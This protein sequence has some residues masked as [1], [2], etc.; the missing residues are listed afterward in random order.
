MRVLITGGA[1]FVAPYVVA[2]LRA[3]VHTGLQLH[4]TGQSAAGTIGADPIHAL[5]VTDAA[6]VDKAVAAVLPTHVVHL[7]GIS[8]LPAAAADPN[9]AW[10]VNVLGTLNLA[11]SVLRHT[12]EAVF[13]FAG[14]SQAY[15]GAPSHGGPLREQDPLLP[16]SEYGATKAAADLGLGVLALEGLRAIRFRLFNHTGP[17]QPENFAVP[18]F[19]GQ[20]VRIERGLQ[21]PVIHVG[22]LEAERDILDVRDVADAYAAAILRARTIPAGTILNIASGR[23]TRI[24]NL[25][26]EL[27]AMAHLPV[28]VVVD[29]A[30]WRQNDIPVLVGDPSAARALLAWEPKISL[31]QTISDLLDARRSDP[32]N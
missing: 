17:R 27:V 30:R 3:H 12:P 32:A 11:R 6:E 22:N 19:A 13:I 23:G 9:L 24:R 14:S 10:T 18:S 7:A 25:L 16:T 8:A 5:D 21:A 20:I 1:G 4:I 15:G 28:T 26:D 2:A 29:P 31:R